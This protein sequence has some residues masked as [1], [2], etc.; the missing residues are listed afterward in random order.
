M[1]ILMIDYIRLGDDTDHGGKI[2]SVSP[3]MRFNGR[4][5]ARKGD[6]VSCQN[7]KSILMQLSKQMKI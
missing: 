7:A 4:A 2:V 6:L 5:I 3:T 1:R